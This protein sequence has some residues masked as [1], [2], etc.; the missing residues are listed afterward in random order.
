[1]NSAMLPTFDKLNWSRAGRLPIVSLAASR[2]EI[3]SALG[4]GE[5]RI[6]M[7]KYC[8]DPAAAL[9]EPKGAHFLDAHY[10]AIRHA[11][12]G[13]VFIVD[14]RLIVRSGAR[15]VEGSR[16]CRYHPSGR[17]PRSRRRHEP[18]S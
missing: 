13:L 16:D 14:D 5:H 3:V 7:R 8:D 12:P 15:I 11:V 18:E 6:G 10:E 9:N 2:T 4:A 1:M 17:T